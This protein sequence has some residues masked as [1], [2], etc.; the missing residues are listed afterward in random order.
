MDYQLGQ[1]GRAS[2]DF[3]IDLRLVSNKLEPPAEQFAAD[4]GFKFP[5]APETFQNDFDSLHKEALAVLN[6]SSDFRVLSLCRDWM[7]DQHGQIAMD[8]F[9][10]IR[11]QLVPQL[12]ALASGSVSLALDES[13]SLPGYWDGYEFHRS[14]GGWDGHDYMGFVHGELIHFHM[15]GRSLAGVLH[16]QRV[17]AAQAAPVEA[18]GTILEMG[19][20]SGQFTQALTE[21]YPDASITALDLS[22]RQLEQTM[23]RGNEQGFDWTLLQANAEDTGLDPERF[24][25]VCSYA[26]FHELPVQAATAVLH[27]KF[28]LLKPGGVMLMADVKS[29]SAHR[30]AQLWNAD[31]WNQVKGG[32]P[33]WREYATTDF[34][35][36]AA[37]AGFTDV[38]WGG[39]GEHAYPFILT[40]RKP[41]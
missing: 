15:V 6:E 27:E 17:A 37:D 39:H 35:A 11:E 28:R 26:M 22:P 10:E 32:D 34:A 7:L 33:F 23:R 5:D 25:L 9:E 19:C 38:S 12:G 14:S 1:R 36:L 31:Y 24:D 29:Y 8:A 13:L 41:S 20:A 21:V 40:G 30:G 16:A 18:P 2:I 3:L 4:S